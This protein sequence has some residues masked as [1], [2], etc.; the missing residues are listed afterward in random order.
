[1][2]LFTL[3]RNVRRRVVQDDAHERT[4]N[5][6]VAVIFDQAHFAEPVH[7][8]TYPRSGRADDCGERLLTHLDDDRLRTAILAEVGQEK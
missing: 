3:A 2:R 4:V 8:E 1:V 6:H 5:F 7:E